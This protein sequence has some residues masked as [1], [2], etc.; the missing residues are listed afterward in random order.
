ML[1]MS[2][3]AME[4]HQE[5]FKMI[6]LQVHSLTF[7]SFITQDIIFIVILYFKLSLFSQEFSFLFDHSKIFYF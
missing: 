6:I 2:S 4:I 1:L 5:E 3:K 7:Q